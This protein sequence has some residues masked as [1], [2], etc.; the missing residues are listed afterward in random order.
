MFGGRIH[1]RE[2]PVVAAKKKVDPHQ[3]L[4]C[5]EGDDDPGDLRLERDDT[6]DLGGDGHRPLQAVD[7]LNKAPG[8]SG[9]AGRRG[10]H[11]Q[12]GPA[13]ETAYS[14]AV[15]DSHLDPKTTS[16]KNSGRWKS[17]DGV[18]TG[19]QAP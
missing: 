13:E 18:S 16:P 8:L 7:N 11:Y 3:P 2:K 10:Q 17:G 14:G 15:R 9:K 12:R 5:P 4:P 1:E 6:L 19:F